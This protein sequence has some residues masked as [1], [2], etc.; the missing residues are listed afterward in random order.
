[1]CITPYAALV[2]TDFWNSYMSETTE[3][4]SLAETPV[5]VD[6]AEKPFEERRAVPRT[7][8][9]MECEAVLLDQ[10]NRPSTRI[11]LRDISTRGACFETS[12]LFRDNEQLAIVMPLA[13][14]TGRIVLGRICYCKKVNDTLHLTGAEFL[15][16]MNLPR[17]QGP[18]RIPPKWLMPR[19]DK[20]N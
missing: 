17:S 4:Q 3:V 10:P 18:I 20:K 11:V 7:A 19:N 13:N 9:A 16:A 6:R 8:V 12:H 15:D 1:M 2:V 14:R 5:S